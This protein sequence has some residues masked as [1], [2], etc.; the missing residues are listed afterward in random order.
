[1]SI[2]SY[3]RSRCLASLCLA[4]VLGLGPSL[5]AQFHDDFTGPAVR[6]EWTWTDPGNDCTYQIGP[7]PGRLRMTV[8]PGND[9]TTGH[10]PPLYAGCKLTVPVT[11][12]FAITT[13]VSINYPPTPAAKES[14]LMLWKDTSNNL[15]FKR[16]NAYNSQNVLLYGN[17][18][19][20]TTTQHGQVTVAA[21]DLFLRVA[22]AGNLF[23]ASFSLDGRTWT[24]A[25][26]V[27]WPAAAALEVGL[28]TSYWLWF[29]SGT[30][31]A[32]GDYD[33]F[34]VE[35]PGAS[36]RA[37]RAGVPGPAGGRVGLSLDLGAAR[38]GE[39]YLVLGSLSGSV[40]GILLPGGAVLPLNFDSLTGLMLSMPNA[41]GLFTA[42]LGNLDGAGKA[43][44]A[45]TV[46]PGALVPLTGRALRFAA[47]VS[48]ASL[49]P[50]RATNAVA[51][52][53]VP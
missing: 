4:A 50:I 15:Q 49:F 39:Y 14:G 26:S 28:S 43:G 45:V 12:D 5:G 19:N 34:D 8:P 33:F 48:D 32:L 36:L 1:M 30:A 38:A 18:A 27:A 24:A 52:G 21:N 29:G 44:A 20:S 3:A 13:H 11:G 47:A 17:I 6:P 40:P 10:G 25:G 41:S 53:I 16:T 37:D 7:L 2:A 35:V 9:H 31:P 46:P 22:R 23:T 51:L 42:T